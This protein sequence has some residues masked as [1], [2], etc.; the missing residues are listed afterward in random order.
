MQTMQLQSIQVPSRVARLLEAL[1]TA[2]R[3]MPTCAYP[4]RDVTQMPGHLL[5][6]AID[7]AAHGRAWS[8][9]VDG[10]HTSLFTGEMSLPLSRERGVPVLRVDRYDDGGLRDSASWMRDGD[11]NWTVC[12]Q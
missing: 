10:F 4:I 7:A 1:V 3:L 5:R 8:C 11:G 6:T 9:W 2:E 12:N